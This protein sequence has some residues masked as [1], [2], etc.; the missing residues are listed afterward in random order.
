MLD[1]LFFGKE[2]FSPLAQKM[3]PNSTKARRPLTL[4]H[5]DNQGSDGKDNPREIGS[6]PIQTHAPAT[7]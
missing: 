4:I 6:F 7:V 1:S 3:Q 2:M 5:M